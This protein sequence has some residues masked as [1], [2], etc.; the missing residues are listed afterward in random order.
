MTTD[1][2]EENDGVIAKGWDYEIGNL[3]IFQFA[4]RVAMY[5]REHE[6]L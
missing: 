2:D 6:R 4:H 5:K 1:D 3:F